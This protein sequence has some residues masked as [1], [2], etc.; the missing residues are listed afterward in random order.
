MNALYD[1]VSLSSSSKST[2]TRIPSLKDDVSKL[3][4]MKRRG[5]LSSVDIVVIGDEQ[6]VF[7]K[8]SSK[9]FAYGGAYHQP[10]KKDDVIHFLIQKEHSF[11][12]NFVECIN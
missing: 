12:I 5:I 8:K 1:D 7:L 6:V 9:S 10:W 2:K 4:V 3:E 11:E